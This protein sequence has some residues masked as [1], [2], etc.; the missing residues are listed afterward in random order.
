MNEKQNNGHKKIKQNLDEQP[1]NR[2][3]QSKQLVC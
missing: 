3:T 2:I 1:K